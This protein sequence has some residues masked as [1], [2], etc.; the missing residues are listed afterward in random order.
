MLNFITLKTEELRLLDLTKNIAI[1]FIL[2]A[3]YWFV[4]DRVRKSLRNYIKITRIRLVVDVIITMLTLALSFLTISMVFVD[5]LNAF[6]GGLGLV[7]TA[8]VFTL[9]DF[10]ASF[11][12]W[13]HLRVNHLYG[14]GDEIVVHSGKVKYVGKVLKI[15]IFRTYLK[16][17]LGDETPD[18]EMMLGRVV[19]FPNHL[20][21]KDA[22]DNSTRTNSILWHKVS[23]TI[24]FESDWQ[25]T[26]KLFAEIC[27]RQFEYML[28]KDNRFLDGNLN[29]RNL[30]KPKVYLD[31]SD[32]GVRFTVWVACNIGYYRE[33]LQRYSEDVLITFAQNNIELAYPT[34]R[35]MQYRVK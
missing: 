6:F 30:Y 25:L 21:L 34:V 26:K 9:Q 2:I 1:S 4:L 24:T 35:H 14:M 15:G 10:V 28:S 22:V 20:V 31:I 17:R 23:W 5:N 13:L 11:F 29:K 3:F 7:S 32:D 18:R 19:S 33:I 8:L 12:G 16:I 27:T